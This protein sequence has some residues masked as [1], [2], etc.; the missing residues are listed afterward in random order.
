M[1]KLK[2]ATCIMVLACF[3]IFLFSNAFVKA[4][5]IYSGSAPSNLD[6][7]LDITVFQ[8]E[9]SEGLPNDVAGENHRELIDTI[10]DGVVT[11][12]N[13]N[14]IEIGLN[15][16]DS[17]ISKEIDNRS[18]SWLFSSKTLGSMDYWER[19][20]IA[21][22]F[23][24]DTTGLTF[25]IYFPDGVADTY[26]L[27]TTSVDLGESSPSV[28]IGQDIYPIYQTILQKNEKGQWVATETKVGYAD[29]AYYSNPVTGS[30]FVKYPSFDPATWDEGDLGNS[31]GDAVI[32]NAGETV[33]TYL[34]LP[35]DSR[36]YKFTAKSNKNT[37][38]S[39]DNTYA[40]FNVYNSNGKLLDVNGQGT[41]AITFKP[42]NNGVYYIEVSGDTSI[43]FK[44]TQ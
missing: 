19:N 29:S 21:D 30:L 15:N 28:P 17:Y 4:Q 34:T 31:F 24:L 3:A 10:L 32:V 13:G 7:D 23:N 42:T 20:D 40:K 38:I 6:L 1:K 43:T 25:L 44:I 36:Y 2:L 37:A 35:T 9:G 18:T 11:D 8:W 5:W 16:S 27:Y 33:T 41:S 26:Y 14:K 39:T 12:K 22:Y